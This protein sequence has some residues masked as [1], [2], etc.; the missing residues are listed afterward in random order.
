MGR[1][2]YCST[3]KKEKEESVRETSQCKACKSERMKKAAMNKRI[4][5][6]LPP[7]RLEREAYC[8]ECK[9]KKA[10]GI[11]IEGRCNPCTAITNK[12]RLHEKRLLEGKEPVPIRDSSFCH[13]CNIPKV[14][15]RCIPCRQKMA[16]ERKAKKREEAGKRAWGS[17]R[18][19]TCYKCGEVKENPENSHCNTCA[20]EYNKKRWVEVIV[21]KMERQTTVVKTPRT[22]LCPCGSEKSVHHKT[23]CKVCLARKA[24]ERRA[25]RNEGKIRANIPLTPEEKRA[26]RHARSLTNSEIR[27]GF[28]IP[29]PCEVCGTNIDIDA[30]HDDYSKPLDV[31]WLCRTHHNEHHQTND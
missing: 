17:G 22:G 26:R 27:K 21:P 18:P 5:R 1:S 10:T 15:G 13:V 8:E 24:R 3:C 9:I 14:E 29:K 19:L 23:Y 12:M 25:R 31:R 20:S 30:H 28:L 6:G 4:A 11:S 16:R 2:I 7:T